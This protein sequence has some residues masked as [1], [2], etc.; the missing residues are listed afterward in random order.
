MRYEDQR[1]GRIDPE[2]SVVIVAYNSNQHLIKCLNSLKQQ[3][4]SNFEIILVD[5]GGNDAV[6]DEILAFELL[7]IRL[8]KNYLP[9]R[10]R[11][12]GLT[13]TRGNVVCFLDDDALADRDFI[14]Q[15]ISAHMQANI[16]GVRGKVL[17]K[18][19]NPYN[20]LAAMYDLGDQPT[21]SYIDLEGNSSFSREAIV[22]VG[23]FN[24]T[25]FAGEG[26]E[27][28][29]RLIS[30]FGGHENLLYWPGAVIYHD[31]SN[32]LLKCFERPG[33]EERCIFSWMD[34]T[35]TFGILLIHTILYRILISADRKISG[36]AFSWLQ[37]A[38]R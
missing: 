3:S 38:G 30:L 36:N 18:S 12:I 23:G 29:Y 22:A 10:A 26:V 2:A 17:P 25:I 7:Y 14:A 6:I 34:C 9:S 13:Y 21:P 8:N 35:L 4:F 11:N 31:Y 37:L 20:N 19:D 16:L 32:S 24:P 5:N 27:L 33:A 1:V 28:S 15:H